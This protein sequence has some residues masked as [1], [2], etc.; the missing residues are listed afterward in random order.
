MVLSVLWGQ[1]GQKG[2][3]EENSKVVRRM[4]ASFLAE[5][6]EATPGGLE[7]QEG[8]WESAGAP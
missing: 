1:H 3:S 2:S 6:G 5:L 4:W 7:K 8:T